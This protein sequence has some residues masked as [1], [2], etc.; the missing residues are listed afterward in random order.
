[1]KTDA[2]WQSIAREEVRFFGRVSA[3]IS[4]EINNRFAVINEK[5]G[6]LQDLAGML[7]QGR[8]VDPAR[9]QLQ[10]GKIAEQVRLAKHVVGNLNRFAH[11]VDIEHAEIDVAELTGF[12]A[13]L[14]ARK[15]E[16]ADVR[17]TVTDSSESTTVTTSPFA[18]ETLIGRGI[19]IALLKTGT[20]EAVAIETLG[21]AEGVRLRYCGLEDVTEPVELPEG[22]EVGALLEGLGAAFSAEADGTALLLDIPDDRRSPHG[23]T[24]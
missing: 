21:T 15:A 20:S 7:A 22:A 3:A 12:V 18:L 14:Y 16:M 6:L 23:R 2:D 24:A 19:E 13:T 9:I 4:H 11:S 17:L 5:A 8:E 1:M 10:S